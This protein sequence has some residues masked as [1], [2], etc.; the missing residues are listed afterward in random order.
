MDKS[1]A[2]QSASLTK[3]WGLPLE[4]QANISIQPPGW[5]KE[6]VQRSQSIVHYKVR[7]NYISPLAK[8]K[9]S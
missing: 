2:A 8:E 6:A 9:R 1:I 7:R 4:L 3:Q 5:S